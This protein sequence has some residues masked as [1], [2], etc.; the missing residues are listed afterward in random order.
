MTLALTIF[1]ILVVLILIVCISVVIGEKRVAR[2]RT[3][4]DVTKIQLTLGTTPLGVAVSATL[5]LE[6]KNDDFDI[7]TENNVFYINQYDKFVKWA[8]SY[9]ATNDV[10]P[11]FDKFTFGCIVY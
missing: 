5:L 9:G 1:G 11:T 10:L 8:R 7:I 6:N 2:I 4:Y 3:N